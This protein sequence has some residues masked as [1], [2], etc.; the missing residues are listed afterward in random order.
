MGCVMPSEKQRIFAVA[1][2]T[3]AELKLLGQGFSR[4][5]RV[6]QTPCFGTLLAAIDDADREM[7]LELQSRSAS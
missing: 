5:Y 4:A 7:R 2:V 6:D 3:E 1:L